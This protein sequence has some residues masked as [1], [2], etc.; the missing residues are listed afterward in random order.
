MERMSLSASQ[1]GL[2]GMEIGSSFCP[3]QI[4]LFWKVSF[5]VIDLKNEYTFDP[6]QQALSWGVL[7]TYLTK[8]DILFVNFTKDSPKLTAVITC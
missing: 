6:K 1:E 5:L 2:H 7:V 4:Q 3:P 8:M